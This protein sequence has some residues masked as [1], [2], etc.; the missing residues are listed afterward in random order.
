MSAL[1]FVLSG[2]GDSPSPTAEKKAEAVK[3]PEPVT[4][5]TGLY[6]MYAMAR[7]WAP[8]AQLLRA[9]SIRLSEVKSDGGKSGAWEAT[10]VSESGRMA[11][12]YTFSVVEAQGNLHEGV[13]AGQQEGYSGPTAQVRPF[14][15]NVARVDSEK[16]YET[17]MKKG[18][19]YA[20]KHPDVPISFLLELVPGQTNPTWRVIWGESV[21]TS[22]Y[23]V[24]VD[25][26]TGEVVQILR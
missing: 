25:A 15:I 10:F 13:F 19:E 16:A 9:R 2:C 22:G 14:P 7:Q 18:E 17:A 24:L 12:S 11:R 21:A 1:L 20:K 26:A 23:S 3:P 8:D 4:G 5:L 6:R